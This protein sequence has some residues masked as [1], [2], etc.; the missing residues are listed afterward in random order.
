MKSSN[1]DLLKE[2]S[3]Q[4]D[5][6]KPAGALNSGV[7]Y[8]LKSTV[9]WIGVALK[10][11]F[12]SILVIGLLVAYGLRFS[13]ITI[14]P[15]TLGLYGMASLPFHRPRGL[16]ATG[17]QALL[18]WRTSSLVRFGT[19]PKES[20]LTNFFRNYMR[21]WKSPQGPTDIQQGRGTQRQVS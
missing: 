2:A 10:I 17:V 12:A 1:T 9:W 3:V 13:V 20:N 14:G 19:H 5:A 7:F 15:F 11:G 8:F 18:S 4:N 16:F 21:L 6:S